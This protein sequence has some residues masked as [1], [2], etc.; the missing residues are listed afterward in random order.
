MGGKLI[1]IVMEA[2]AIAIDKPSTVKTQPH[3]RFFKSSERYLSECLAA[4]FEQQ[5]DLKKK[6]GN[7]DAFSK[8]IQKLSKNNNSLCLLTEDYSLLYLALDR[9]PSFISSDLSSL[10][11]HSICDVVLVPGAVLIGCIAL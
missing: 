2:S 1:V 9:R 11:E 6:Y 3:S 5:N 7:F 8:T 10:K 4:A